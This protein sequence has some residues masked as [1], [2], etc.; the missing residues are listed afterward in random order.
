MGQA[1]RRG[2]FEERKAKAEDAHRRME[3]MPPYGSMLGVP[4][5][6]S[7][8]FLD[9]QQ[10]GQ[11]QA[12]E[13]RRF[14]DERA[15]YL[16]VLLAFSEPFDLEL[17]SLDTIIDRFKSKTN[18]VLW[19]FRGDFLD[20]TAITIFDVE[21]IPHIIINAEMHQIGNVDRQYH[22]LVDSLT[23]EIAHATGPL[24]GRWIIEQQP[25]LSNINESNA[26]SYAVEEFIA[27]TTALKLYGEHL[28][29]SI[30]QLEQFRS[31]GIETVSKQL[32][33]TP[34]MKAKISWDQIENCSQEVVDFLTHE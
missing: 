17:G 31:D 14:L 28:G 1:K 15:I 32:Q 3:K 11:L 23:H 22:E 20:C 10:V 5:H 12:R 16:Q 33:I 24:L 7:Q 18:G 27:I 8:E 9:K 26:L 29:I 30:E 4:F 25:N 6:V 2:S 13:D 21:D 19:I 34:E